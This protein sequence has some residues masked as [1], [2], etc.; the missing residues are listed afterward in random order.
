MLI[1]NLMEV[2]MARFTK[3]QMLGVFL[4]G[5]VAGAAAALLVAPK[6]GAQTRR[7]IRRFSR[8]AASEGYDQV[9]EM[10]ENA[11]EYVEDGKIKLQKLI[12]IA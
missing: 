1:L 3:K 11:K 4:T 5:A 12:Q 8:N 9:M 10:I 7:D 6:S 2:Y